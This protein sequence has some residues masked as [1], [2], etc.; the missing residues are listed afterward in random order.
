MADRIYTPMGASNHVD[1]ARAADDFYATDPGSIDKL[2]SVVQLPNLIWE[3]ACGTG[4]L[5]KKLADLGYTVYSSDLVDRGFGEARGLDFFQC[6]AIPPVIANCDCILTNPPYSVAED[7]I[8]HALDLLPSGGLCIMF[9]K[10]LFLEGQRRYINLFREQP[11]RYVLPF[12]KRI[13]C[14]HGGKV[15]G[16]KGSGAVSYSWFVWEKDWFGDPVIK[17][18]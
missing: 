3:P 2:L 8:L 13:A 1:F 14:R 9:L 10:T 18:I 4:N 12:S 7:F 5:S 15:S 17:W 11:P 16:F 6:N